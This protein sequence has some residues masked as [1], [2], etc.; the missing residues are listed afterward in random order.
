MSSKNRLYGLDKNKQAVVMSEDNGLTWLTVSKNYY[1][2]EK[3]APGFIPA[4][5]VPWNVQ[6]AS[7]PVAQGAFSGWLWFEKVLF[8]G[9]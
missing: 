3:A 8:S 5:V 1:L 6:I 2:V 4:K 9:Q 7:T